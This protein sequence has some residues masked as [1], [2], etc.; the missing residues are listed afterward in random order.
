MFSTGEALPDIDA[1]LQGE[2]ATRTTAFTDL[3][4]LP[5]EAGGER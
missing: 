4:R 5:G 1:T 2:Q 3:A